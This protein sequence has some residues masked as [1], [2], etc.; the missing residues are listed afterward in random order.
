MSDCRR[1]RATTT[2]SI[3]RSARRRALVQ[4]LKW[5]VA[6]DWTPGGWRVRSVRCHRPHAQAA[7]SRGPGHRA[8]GHEPARS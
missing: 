7:R 2:K 1:A 3:A 8:D 4:H 5:G 6:R